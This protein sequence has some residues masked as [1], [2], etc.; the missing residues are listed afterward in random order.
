MANLLAQ[1]ENDE[2]ADAVFIDGGYGTGVVSAG[3]TMGRNWQIVWFSGESSD[4]GCLNKR[5]EMWK[6]IRDWLKAGGAIPKDQV[7]YNDLIGPETVPRLDGKLQLESKQHMKDRG[8]P[9]PGRGDALGLSFAYPVA[10]INRPLP[11]GAYDAGYTTPE[12]NI[13]WKGR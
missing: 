6:G 4:Q 7:L 5:A 2:K 9:S 1:F 8:L 12:S 13:F 10:A 3:N 11:F